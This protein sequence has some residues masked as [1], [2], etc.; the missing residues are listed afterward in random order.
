MRVVIEGDQVGNGRVAL[1]HRELQLVHAAVRGE[2]LGQR[3]RIADAARHE[4]GRE[5]DA[6]A[7]ERNV[8]R[9]AVVGGGKPL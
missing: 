7:Q 6:F 9:H 2:K 8:V 1:H 3:M 4:F 5:V